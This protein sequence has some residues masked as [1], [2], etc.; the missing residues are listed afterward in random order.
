MNINLIGVFPEIYDALNYGVVGRAIKEKIISINK[1]DLKKFSTN[2]HKTLDDKPY[3]GGEGVLM[4]PIPL[5]NA[6]K[7][8]D[9][10]GTLILL[11]PQ[12]SRFNHKK[13]KEL[14]EHNN[15]TIISG[16]YEG[17]DQRFIDNEVDEEISLGDYVISG[18]EI[19]GCVL[20][21]AISRAKNGVLGNSKSFEK[22]SFANGMLKHHSYTKPENFLGKK[23][24]KVLLSGNHKKIQEWK[25]INSLWVTKQKR[26]DLFNELQLSDEEMVLLEQYISSIKALEGDND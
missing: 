20:V 17:I 4:S 26:P 19:A 16:R 25:Y 12:G 22:D 2:K 15:L 13:A 1:V 18:G 7:S 24:P 5:T 8:L 14:S 6:V 10:K 23:V 3:G 11:S 9:K 21:D